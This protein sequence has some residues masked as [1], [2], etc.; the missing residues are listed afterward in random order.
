MQCKLIVMSYV[1]SLVQ[2][3]SISVEYDVA[4]CCC[5]EECLWMTLQ[6]ASVMMG[7]SCLMFSMMEKVCVCV[8]VVVSLSKK[9]ALVYPAVD[10][11]QLRKQPT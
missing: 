1:R 5:R 10:W 8:V 6:N 7:R 9:L 4:V 11:C 2:P 3:V